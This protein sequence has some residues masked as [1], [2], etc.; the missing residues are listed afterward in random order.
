MFVTVC[1]WIFLFIFDKLK[2]E[3]IINLNMKIL[4]I[5][6][7]LLSITL[8]AQNKNR[9]LLWDKVNKSP[10]EFATIKSATNYSLSNEEGYFE[11]VKDENVIIQNLSYETLAINK[12][13]LSNRDTIFLNPKI[14]A[15][16]EAVV[17]RENLYNKMLK[18]VLEE[19]AFIPHIEKFYLRVVVRKNKSLYKIIDFSGLVEKQTLF[20]TSKI[21]L[22]KNN[23]KVQIN[24]VRK[25]GIEDRKVD[26]ELYNFNNFFTEIASV[27]SQSQFYNFR[28]EASEDKNNSRIIATP[29]PDIQ[30]ISN[31]VYILNDDNTF[32]EV[33][34][35][36]SRSTTPFINLGKYKH[37]TIDIYKKS[38][39][40]R[41]DMN[42]KIQL[43]KAIFK[44]T[45]ELLKEDKT[46][47]IFDVSYLYFANPEQNVIVKNNINLNKDM[48][49]I[50]GDY[51]DNYWNNNNV[52]PLSTEMQ[53]FINSVN[54]NSKNKEFR[55]K[56]NMN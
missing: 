22:P 2:D 34:M 21:P 32:G 11:V 13:E 25:V 23:Y 48:F 40:Q 44:A 31:N 42:N 29:K 5:L 20:S 10:I 47:E 6:I 24:N 12:E 43:N 9:K 14:F 3:N 41:N 52:L 26:Y 15:L 46:K 35:V 27:I 4:K 38:S 28:Y 54:K 56:S 16:E 33:E 36:N 8:N 50:N 45:T 17:T 51:N 1:N 53:E 19:Y 55:S 18:T 37:R 7:V 49:E 30:N 39:F